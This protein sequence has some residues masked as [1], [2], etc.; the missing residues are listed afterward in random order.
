MSEQV[1]YILLTR[2]PGERWEKSAGA[3]SRPTLVRKRK[4]FRVYS[5]AFTKVVEVQPDEVEAEV[6]AKTNK[7]LQL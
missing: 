2:Q 7:G 4:R 5:D 3:F 6:I 1:K